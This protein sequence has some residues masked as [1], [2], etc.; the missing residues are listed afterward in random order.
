MAIELEAPRSRRAVLTAAAAATAASVVAAIER[1]A[2]AVAGSDGDVALGQSNPATKTTSIVTTTPDITVFE[3]RAVAGTAPNGYWSGIAVHGSVVRSGADDDHLGVGVLGEGASFCTG[4]EG[5]SES[6]FGV[7]GR[8]ESGTG[9]QGGSHDGIGVDGSSDEGTGVH[10]VCT[11]GTGVHAESM[12]GTAL[13]AYGKVKLHRSGRA[14]IG[15][16]KRSVTVDLNSRSGLG[17]M[18]LCFANLMTYRSGVWVTV[19][20]PNYPSAGKLQIYLNRTVTAR[21]AVAWLVLDAL[22]GPAPWDL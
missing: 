1:P 13:K 9:T 18:P 19:V 17:G 11:R 21:T 2:V 8:S 12:S 7:F 10:A 15:A 5:R 20:R 4:V 14:W 16:R 3:T 6:G 22:P